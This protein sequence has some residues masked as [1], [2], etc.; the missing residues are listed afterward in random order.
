MSRV[1]VIGSPGAGKSTFAKALAQRSGLP[2]VHLDAEYWNPGWVETPKDAW[3]ARLAEI[4]AADRW[5]MDGNYGGSLPQRIA[6]PDTIVVLDYPTWLCL[7]RIIKRWW[8]HRGISRPDM[9]AD[10]PERLDP[11]FLLYVARFR[12]NKRWRN[13]AL[14]TQFKGAVHRFATQEAAASWLGALPPDSVSPSRI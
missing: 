6:A 2:L 10:C 12:Q 13:E 3:E 4:I 8:T 7:S 14:L 5:V 11:S 9:A 1:L